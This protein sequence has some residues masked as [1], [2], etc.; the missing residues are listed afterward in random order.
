M[1]GP[2]G[3]TGIGIF[4]TVAPGIFAMSF[5]SS[6][7]KLCALQLITKDLPRAN[8]CRAWSS[9]WVKLSG[10]ISFSVTSVLT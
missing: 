6:F 1:F 10:S 9:V 8:F 4:T 2:A 5:F 3:P 7:C